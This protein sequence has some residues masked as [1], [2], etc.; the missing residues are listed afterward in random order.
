MQEPQRIHSGESSI[1]Y[2][3]REKANIGTKAMKLLAI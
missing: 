1:P 2:L 3:S